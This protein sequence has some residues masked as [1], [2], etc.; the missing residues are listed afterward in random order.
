MKK[1]IMLIAMLLPM[2]A[3]ASIPELTALMERYSTNE[4]ATVVNLNGDMLKM[5]MAESGEADITGLESLNVL[6]TEHA[7]LSAEIATAMETLLQGSQ[8]TT[9]TDITADGAHVKILAN[10]SGETLGDVVVYVREGAEL[11]VVHISGTIPES[12]LSELV[13]GMVEM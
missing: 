10:K 1:I 11:V 9:L 7:E 13:G 12:M 5:A 3:M 2:S 6:N 4:N 8:L